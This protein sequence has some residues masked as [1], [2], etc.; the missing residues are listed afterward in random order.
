MLEAANI[1]IESGKEPKGI[2]YLKPHWE[3]NWI[4]EIKTAIIEP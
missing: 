2:Y 3:L 4:E 1:Y